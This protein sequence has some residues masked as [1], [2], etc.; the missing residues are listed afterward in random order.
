MTAIVSALDGNRSWRS[1]RSWIRTAIADVETSSSKEESEMA[2]LFL[3][4]KHGG[5][6]Y[7]LG[8][9]ILA[10]WRASYGALWYE[11]E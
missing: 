8:N 2:H 7:E 1:Y 9:E 11:N 5:Y 3:N 4:H 6:L 10:A